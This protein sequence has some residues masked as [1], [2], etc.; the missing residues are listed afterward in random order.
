MAEVAVAELFG[1][2]RTASMVRL[3]RVMAGAISNFYAIF[4]TQIFI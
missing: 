4:N 1:L 2:K 3:R